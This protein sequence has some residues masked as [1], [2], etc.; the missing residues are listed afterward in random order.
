MEK[1]DFE[2]MVYIL[3]ITASTIMLLRS[4]FSLNDEGQVLLNWKQDHL[5]DP[6]NNLSN[7]NASD[8]AP[9][10]LNDIHNTQNSV[11]AFDFSSLVNLTGPIHAITSG[12]S[13]YSCCFIHVSVYNATLC[14]PRMELIRDMNY[15]IRLHKIKL[16]F[17][18]GIESRC[19]LN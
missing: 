9:R 15:I 12:S 17:F 8:A 5:D 13:P 14:T 1:M 6:D 2:L 18:Y 7:W 10:Q 3:W 4:V 16:V 11:S 19:T